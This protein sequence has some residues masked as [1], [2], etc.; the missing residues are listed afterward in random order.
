M[1]AILA[2]LALMPAGASAAAAS[3]PDIEDEVM[4]TICGTTLQLSSSPQA[5]RERD[6][7]NRLIAQG[8]DK[9]EIK[10]ALVAEYGENVLA[11][12]EAS[13]FGLA[14]FIVP[15]A[16]VLIALVLVG[17]AARRWRHARDSNAPGAGPPP[18]AASDAESERL[19]SDLG[20]YHL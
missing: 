2:L 15:I 17:L 12:P 9:D 19:D 11:V 6:F 18:P 16:G 4:C 13:G 1:A 7:I 3:L 5:E 10:Q 20:R 8:E 14:A